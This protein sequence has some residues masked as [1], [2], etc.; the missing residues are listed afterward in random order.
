MSRARSSSPA[1][2]I[3][4]ATEQRLR[5]PSRAGAITMVFQEPMTSLNPLHAIERQIGEILEG[6]RHGAGRPRRRA[7]TF[8]LLAEVG[9]RDPESRLNAYPHQLSGGQRQRVMIAMALANRPD[10]LIADEP[11]TALDVT[12]QAQ[13][14]AL[15][16]DLQGKHG[17]AMLFITHDL[18]IVRRLA[19]DVAVMQ[20]GKIVEQAG[21]VSRI[22][23]SPQ[24]PYTKMLLAAEPKGLAPPLDLAAQPVVAVND[25]RVHFPDPQRRDA[26]GRRRGEG[27]RRHLA[28]R[29]RGADGRRRRRVG[30]G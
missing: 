15:L 17:M 29:A 30:I 8:E 6:A 19:D 9:L 14:L 18:G 27:S 5:G 1:E 2:D 23:A 10:L 16:K 11:T 7:R 4:N 22:F 12:V 25:V 20:K 21:P 24:H 28:R 26:T 3:T 13:I